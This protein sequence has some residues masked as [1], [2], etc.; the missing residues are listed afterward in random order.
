MTPEE[1]AQMLI[2]CWNDLNTF[3][4]IY[5]GDEEGH[6]LEAVTETMDSIDRLID[7]LD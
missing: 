7:M 2:E 3:D 4:P 5:Y 6:L 1:L